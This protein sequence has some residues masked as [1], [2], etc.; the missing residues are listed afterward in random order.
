MIDYIYNAQERVKLALNPR[1]RNE[2]AL[3]IATIAQAEA[4]IALARQQ[5]VANLIALGEYDLYPKIR[6]ELGLV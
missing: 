4:T 1:K 6:E 2:E 3:T 5:R